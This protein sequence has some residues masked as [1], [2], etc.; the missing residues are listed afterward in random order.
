M[1]L[2]M[3][4][5]LTSI[6][7]QAVRDWVKDRGLPSYRADQILK[8]AY[9]GAETFDDMTNLPQSLRDSLKTDFALQEVTTDRVLL[10]EDGT[11]KFLF[12]ITGGEKV[13]GVL[14]KYKY[15]NSVCISTQAGCRMGCKFCA[16]PPAGFCRNLTAGEMLGQVTEAGKE[17]GGRVDN[18]VLM[19]IGEPLDNFENVVIFLKNLS[20]PD[21]YQLSLRHVSLSTCGLADKIRELAEH[22][23]GLT[24]SISLHAPNDAIRDKLMPIN[25]KYQIAQLLSAV[26][27]YTRMTGRRVVFEY[28]LIRG[29]NDS[30]ENA[31]ELAALLRGKLCHINLIACNPVKGTG[32]FPPSAQTV[33]KFYKTLEECG[34]SV[35]IRRTMGADLDASCGQL[36]RNEQC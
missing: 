12:A 36:R 27:Y 19:G 33:Q 25:K 9:G 15:G 13:E 21:G 5:G 23:F 10:S 8:W 1:V 34:A 16:S 6:P 32:F 18:I 26:D 31:R 20:A 7:I 17:C 28:A 35:T 30:V 4:Q 2:I 24:L 14:M 3:R 29:V 22:K 11:K